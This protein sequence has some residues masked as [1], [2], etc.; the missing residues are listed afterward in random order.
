MEN[1]R[2]DVMYY[3]LMPKNPRE[4]IPVVWRESASEK[5][6]KKIARRNRWIKL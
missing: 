6:N 2:R 3:G 5:Q 4:V 1:G